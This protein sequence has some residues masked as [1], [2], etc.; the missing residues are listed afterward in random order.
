VLVDAHESEEVATLHVLS[1]RKIGELVAEDGV[2][3]GVHLL[4]AS[5]LSDFHRF[6]VRRTATA[7]EHN[8]GLLELWQ[9]HVTFHFTLLAVVHEDLHDDSVVAIVDQ[10]Y[11]EVYEV[12]P[13]VLLESCR[14]EFVAHHVVVESWD[15][16][17]CKEVEVRLGGMCVGLGID[18]TTVFTL[19]IPEQDLIIH[20][21]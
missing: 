9:E 6:D 12:V 15:F 14:L 13:Y 8:L 4:H 17:I 11:L 5:H 21:F 2:H 19:D 3:M 20:G 10:V 1:A 18:L 16:L 7:G